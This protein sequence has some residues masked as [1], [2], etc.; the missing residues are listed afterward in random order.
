MAIQYAAIDDDGVVD[1]TPG[2]ISLNTPSQNLP[3]TTNDAIATLGDD[4]VLQ[5]SAVPTGADPTTVTPLTAGADVDGFVNQ[6][7]I[8]PN[9]ITEG[10]LFVGDPTGTPGSFSEITP[11]NTTISASALGNLFFQADRDFTGNVAIQYFAVD[12][13]GLED[14][15]PV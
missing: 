1:P 10:R 6:Y 11:G 7:R 2:V 5:L 8:D 4:Q 15:T 9:T 3:P 12:N 13:Q 14:A